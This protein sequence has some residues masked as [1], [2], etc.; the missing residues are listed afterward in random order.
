MTLLNMNKLSL[1]LQKIIYASICICFLM[2]LSLIT[3]SFDSYLPSR[4]ERN[5][6]SKFIIDIKFI[7]ENEA[8]TESYEKVSLGSWS[9]FDDGC[10]CR[11]SI[12][13]E[14]FAFS[15][16]C[17][18]LPEGFSCNKISTI[19]SMIIDT[20]LGG[21]FCV[22]KS[23]FTFIELH[24]NF[25]EYL[26]GNKNSLYDIS[27]KKY[28]EYKNYEFK[29]NPILKNK[30]PTNILIDLKISSKDFIE[31][32][33]GK[34]YDGK[35]YVNLDSYDK[36]EIETKKGKI[37]IYTKYYSSLDSFTSLDDISNLITDLHLYNH[38]WCAYLDLA[39]G[40]DSINLMQSKKKVNQG[41]SF[42]DYQITANADFY[43][44]GY[45]RTTRVSI[46]ENSDLSVLDFYPAAIFDYYNQNP[47]FKDFNNRLKNRV[48]PTNTIEPVIVAERFFD[49]FG[50]RNIDSFSDHISKLNS[51]KSLRLIAI[52]ILI[53]SFILIILDGV[54]Y[55][56]IDKNGSLKLKILNITIL[57]LFGL[58]IFLSIVCMAQASN[59]YNYFSKHVLCQNNLYLDSFYNSLSHMEDNFYF[60]YNVFAKTSIIIF[61]FAILGFAASLIY[62]FGYCF[63][64]LGVKVESLKEAQIREHVA[65][66]VSVIDANQ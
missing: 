48:Y 5:W 23:D 13:Q 19:D 28:N 58:I 50:C 16:K 35:N 62:F 29:N 4:Y 45:K 46:K 61:I 57:A 25:S 18:D 42:C 22:K 21:K 3:I 20:Y 59:T 27:D 43:N 9:G 31:N 12:S 39:F 2:S 10:F 41:F 37:N 63:N 47:N 34:I 51:Y 44:E 60:T 54:I 26:K 15:G 36:K 33:K 53:T 49:G 1:N 24:K 11:H 56:F 32:Y 17:A 38:V 6:N 7:P 64:K 55:Y 66:L 30:I 8:C 52:F 40:T 65:T 14:T